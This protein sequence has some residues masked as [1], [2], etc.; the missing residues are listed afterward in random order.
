[1]INHRSTDDQSSIRPTIIEHRR[2]ST[3]DPHNRPSRFGLCGRGRGIPQ[4]GSWRTINPI[5]PMGLAI[6]CARRAASRARNESYNERMPMWFECQITTTSPYASFSVVHRGE[7][8]CGLIT[9]MPCGPHPLRQI[10]RS[11][12]AV[13]NV[14]RKAAG[15]DTAQLVASLRRVRAHIG[16]ASAD[17]R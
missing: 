16:Q 9:R 6:R 10:C 7:A 1:M 15:L 13:A 3:I 14:C 11:A 5:A 2:S 8:P 17:R 12:L 4:L